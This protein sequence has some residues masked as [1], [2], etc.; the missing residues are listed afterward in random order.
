MAGLLRQGV[1]DYRLVRRYPECPAWEA[2]WDAM[3][4]FY[5]KRRQEFLL[6]GKSAAVYT[7]Y[8]VE[9][10]PSWLVYADLHSGTKCASW[11]AKAGL[12]DLDVRVKPDATH[13]A[14]FAGKK[15]FLDLLRPS[16]ND[17]DSPVWQQRIHDY[18]LMVRQG[19]ID[20]QTIDA[21]EEEARQWY[22]DSEAFFFYPLVWV[23]G[24]A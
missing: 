7:Q 8:L 21:A 23:A 3:V 16:E 24:R 14:T 15:T 20:E 17:A 19:L 4:V 10:N 18:E 13:H 11:F 6:S 22:Q 12:S 2:V 9:R 1:R 5:E